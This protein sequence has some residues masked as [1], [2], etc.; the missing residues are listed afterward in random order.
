MLHSSSAPALLCDPGLASC[1]LWAYDLVW[2]QSGRVNSCKFSVMLKHTE[3]CEERGQWLSE[4]K[5]EL[6]TFWILYT[7][8]VLSVT[9]GHHGVIVH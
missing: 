3:G 5:S 6:Q 2:S 9:C 4:A 1:L 8:P 7:H